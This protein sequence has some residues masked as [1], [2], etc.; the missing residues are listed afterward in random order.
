MVF[1]KKSYPNYQDKMY[2]AERKLSKEDKKKLND[3]LAY[4][5][6]TAGEDKV[7]Q[8]RR[9]VIQFRDV[10]Q[11]PYKKFN[12]IIIEGVYLLIKNSDRE[13]IGKN[14][15]I[16]NLKRFVNWMFEDM[17]LTKNLKTIYL[18]NGVNSKKI[19]SD[20]LIKDK[21]IEALVRACR[22]LKE[23]AMI[24]LCIECAL[25]PQELLSLTWSDAKINEEEGIGDLKVYSNKIKETRV[26]P[27]K[28]SIIHLLRWRDEYQFVDR[29]QDDLIF[30]NPSDRNKKLCRPYLSDLFRRLCRRAGIRHIFP[31]LARHSKLTEIYKNCPEQVASAYAGHSANMGAVYTHLNN[32]DIKEKILERIYNIKEPTI[33]ERK[34]FEK[35]MKQ[36]QIKFVEH[37][38]RLVEIEKKESKRL[39]SDEILNALTKDPE[40]LK[41][42][43]TALGKLGLVDRLM[44]I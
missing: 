4:C 15:A 6:L 11:V 35:E 8:R 24:T 22:S 21:E 32:Q 36:M 31:Y 38:K 30:P 16:K 9:F 10:A 19:N 18:K 27:F 20:T 37:Q 26:I 13:I 33:E 40:S 34:K 44:K 17:N 12:K 42:L 25:R 39:K 14:E 23:K 41:L 43:A 2:L 5:R 3:Y 29:K 28:T 1:M 7:L